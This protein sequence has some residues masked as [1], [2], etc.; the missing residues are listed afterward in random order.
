MN[1]IRGGRVAG[2]F[3]E[4]FLSGSWRW[5]DIGRGSTQ[6]SKAAKQPRSKE[7]KEQRVRQEEGQFEPFFLPQLPA[8]YWKLRPDSSM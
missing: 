4:G 8:K 2:N 5:G 1:K 7:A 3:D 6:S